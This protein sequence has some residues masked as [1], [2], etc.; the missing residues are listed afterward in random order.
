[1]INCIGQRALSDECKF[2]GL[3]STGKAEE[4]KRVI[5]EDDKLCEDIKFCIYEK[6]KEELINYIENTLNKKSKKHA[7]MTNIQLMRKIRK[8]S[9]E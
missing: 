7:E 1:M 6:T 4:L 5:E 9:R 3:K 8:I 2:R